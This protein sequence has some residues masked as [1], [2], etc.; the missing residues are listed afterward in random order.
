M[1]PATFQF[2]DRNPAIVLPMR[3]D[4]SKT[5]LGG[6]NYSGLARLKP[7]VTIAE[8]SADVGRLIPVSLQRF[9]VIPGFNAKMFEEARLGPLVEPLKKTVTGDL[10]HRPVAADGGRR[11]GAA[12]R[13]RERGEPAAREG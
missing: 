5:T 7:G 4:K 2:L 1:L 3:I 9:P 6:F 12:D 11:H 10:E 8:A 13:L